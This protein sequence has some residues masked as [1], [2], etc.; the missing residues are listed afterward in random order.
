MTLDFSAIEAKWR[1]AWYDAKINESVPQP[2]KKKFFMI[3]AYPGVT[4]YLHVGHMRGYTFS[5]AVV[6]Y[7]MMTDHSV[8]FP[9]GTHATGN[10]AISFAKKVERA[11]PTVIEALKAN[12]CSDETIESLSDP[13]E[14]VRFFNGVFVNDY[15]KRFGFMSDWRRFTCTIY[16]DY[17]RFIEWQMRKLMAQG[18]LIQKPYYAAACPEHGPVA[19]DASE[20]DISRGGNAEVLEYALLKFDFEDGRK[21]VAGTLRPETVFGLTNFWV[22]P[23]VEYV[24]VQVGDEIWVTSRPAAEKLRLQKDNVEIQ[25]SANGSSLVGKR[26]R[27][28][29]TAKEIPI[30]PSSLCDP[31]VGSGL[32]MSVPSD[33]PMD[34][35]GLVELKRNMS[36]RN[37]YGITDRMIEE[38]APISIIKTPGWGPLPAVEITQ[39]MGIDSLA[40]SK[41]DDATKEVYKSG[42]HKGIMNDSCGKFA[43]E[44]VERAKVA[45][46][47]EMLTKGQ[48]DLFYDL[49]EEVLCR[50]GNRVLIKKIPD[51]WFI[52]YAN[53]ALTERS[54]A[55]AQTMKILPAEYY[56]NIQ[57]VLEW[58]RERA[59]VRMGNWLGTRFP[60]DQKWI[61][62]AIADSTLYPV[63]YIVSKYVNEGAIRAEHM[64]EEFFDFIL[65]GKGDIASVARNTGFSKGVIESI[66]SEFEY[67]CPLDFNLGGK[68]HMTVH[69]PVFLMNHVAVLRPQHWPRGILV[70][71][72]ITATGGKI[73]KSKG[74][75]QPIPDAAERFGVDAM[76]LFYAHIASLYVDVAWEDEKVEGYRDRLERLWSMVQEL[77]SVG[78]NTSSDVDAWLDARMQTRLAEIHKSMAEYDL[79]SY[80]NDVYF[81]I[82]QD[83][84]WYLRRGG[85]SRQAIMKALESWIPLMAPVT[86]HIAEEIWESIGKD[87]FVSTVQLGQGT[88]TEAVLAE[89][90]KERLLEDLIADVAEILKVTKI[91]PKRIILMAAPR[92]KQE[93]VTEAL[94]HPKEKPEVSSLIKSGIAKVPTPDARKEVPQFAK[95]L[96]ADVAKASSEDRGL[97]SV[98]FD[99]LSVLKRAKSFLETEFACRVEIF[100]ADD[101]ARADPKGKA[102]HAK[103]RRPAVYLE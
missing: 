10:G 91:K 81:E 95:E 19:I 45:I 14:V 101:P 71:W 76:R 13:M 61:V 90:A 16:P 66:R 18:L 24:D 93:M 102:K 32:V 86:P 50:C 70:N 73:S 40:D 60:F 52:D 15:W 78:T 1:N 33:A 96:V 85:K 62:E 99:E 77:M 27:A 80:S 49:S 87:R 31:N 74:G 42:F 21:L 38:A 92:W 44:P 23:D 35:I 89:E 94:A 48:A 51:Q 67:W 26:C 4:G 69:F 59:C 88:V 75:A 37:R 55:H 65:L 8:L 83:I 22:N 84:R 103:P 36:L 6:R 20:T 3:F 56:E 57:N 58:Y 97:M 17:S 29:Y 64:N 30:F 47:E 43:G 2:G 82:P 25:G 100:S 53:P 12:G 7:K 46:R 79:R 11:D 39:K 9:V 54:K 63:Y 68:E 28:P 41:L 5:D 72:Y 98:A 34:W